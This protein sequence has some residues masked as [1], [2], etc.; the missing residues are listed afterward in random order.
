MWHYNIALSADPEQSSGLAQGSATGLWSLRLSCNCS[1]MSTLP[2]VSLLY[3]FVSG[4][5]LCV[6]CRERRDRMAEQTL[7]AF[8]ALGFTAFHELHV[9]KASEP[10]RERGGGESSNMRLVH[11]LS[12][13]FCFSRILCAS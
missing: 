11:D 13:I 10:Q 5:F 9:P 3:E 1:A 2:Y 6:L 7:I 8:F 12:S 4:V